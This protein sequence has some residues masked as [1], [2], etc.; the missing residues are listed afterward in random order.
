MSSLSALPHALAWDDAETRGEHQQEADEER[1]DPAGAHAAVP[2]SAA[3]PAV[4][5]TPPKGNVF[6]TAELLRAKYSKKRPAAA[7]A[8]APAKSKA[9]VLAVPVLPEFAPAEAKALAAPPAAPKA[10]VKA[11][12][13]PPAAPKAKAKALAA[14]P[15][16]PKAKAKA[17]AAPHAK[18]KEKAKALAV[19]P[20]APK[21]KASAAWDNFPM[22]LEEALGRKPEG[23][24]KCR[25]KPGC[26]PSC[27]RARNFRPLI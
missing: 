7:P 12:A 13:A 26:T 23:C 9:K 8:L 16:A 21:A 3:V 18:A 11:C 14:L 4:I 2:K 10:K 6:Q 20:A 1:E 27:W 25:Y 5:A 22:T 15:A 24:G 19:P 17:L